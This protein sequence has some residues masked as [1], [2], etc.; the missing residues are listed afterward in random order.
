M[1]DLDERELQLTLETAR[2]VH[3]DLAPATIYKTHELLAENNSLLRDAL[4]RSQAEG[5]NLV[6]S[7]LRE[8]QVRLLEG[9][10]RDEERRDQ[11]DRDWGA[12]MRRLDETMEE[13]RQKLGAL[14]PMR[15]PA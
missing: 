1:S 6:V 12:S 7:P 10:K 9:L 2:R 3:A 5:P 11:F 8:M 15:R 13:T 14:F 4:G